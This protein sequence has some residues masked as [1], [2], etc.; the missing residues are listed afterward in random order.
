MKRRA[1]RSQFNGGS[2]TGDVGEFLSATREDTVL[3]IGLFVK[4]EM[5][6]QGQPGILSVPASLLI[7]IRVLEGVD[8]LRAKGVFV[9]PPCA[10]N[11]NVDE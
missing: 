9:P 2:T 6:R 3:V 11:Y 10:I 1:F 8:T 4:E 5:L 7:F